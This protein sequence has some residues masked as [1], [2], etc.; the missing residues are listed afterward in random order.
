MVQDHGKAAKEFR[1]ASQNAKDAHLKAWAGKTLPVIEAHLK[2]AQ[3]LDKQLSAS[4]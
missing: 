3:D 2:M 4:R 1:K